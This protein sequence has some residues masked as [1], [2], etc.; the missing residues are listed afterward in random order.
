MNTNCI[1]L[2]SSLISKRLLP[3]DLFST[4]PPSS[5][6]LYKQFVFKIKDFNTCDSFLEHLNN[7]FISYTIT[8][9]ALEGVLNQ[10]S[11]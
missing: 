9:D 7:Y 8:F 4:H 6:K 5:R 1:P 2:H 3:Y 10:T 11:D